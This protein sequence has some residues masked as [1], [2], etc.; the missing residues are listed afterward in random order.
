MSL[1]N[2]SRVFVEEF[3]LTPSTFVEKLGMDTAKRLLDD[4]KRGFEEIASSSPLPR[5]A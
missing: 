1:R 3:G 2:F 5:C 4:G